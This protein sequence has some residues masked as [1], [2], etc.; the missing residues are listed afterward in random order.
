MFNTAGELGEDLVVGCVS[1]Q[2]SDDVMRFSAELVWGWQFRVG[3]CCA[4]MVD[5][6]CRSDLGVIHR[7]SCRVVERVVRLV[8]RLRA[9][10]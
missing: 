7:G 2:V 6:S 1:W 5:K 3:S 4:E 10:G 8:R 9:E